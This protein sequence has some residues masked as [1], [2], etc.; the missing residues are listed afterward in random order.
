MRLL[1]RKALLILSIGVT[2]T[3]LLEKLLFP[4][5]INVLGQ[6][7]LGARGAKVLRQVGGSVAE[8]RRQSL[9]S[10]KK[11]MCYKVFLQNL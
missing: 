2:D 1:S 9:F 6:N 11:L 10:S 8:G 4:M 3:F 5:K 7:V